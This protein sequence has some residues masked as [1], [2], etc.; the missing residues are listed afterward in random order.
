MKKRREFS[1]CLKSLEFQGFMGIR[2][3]MYVDEY[4]ISVDK[5]KQRIKIFGVLGGFKRTPPFNFNSSGFKGRLVRFEAI[6]K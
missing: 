6:K 1:T 3:I 2:H 5:G 4:K